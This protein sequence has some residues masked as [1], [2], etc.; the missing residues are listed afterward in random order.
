[1]PNEPVWTTQESVDVDVPVSSAWAFMTNVANWSDPPAE[2][3]L[4]GPF[5][6][7]AHGTTQMPGQPPTS[8]IVREVAHQRAYT[9]EVSVAAHASVRFQWRFDRVSEQRTTLTQRVELWGDDAAALVDTIRSAFEPSLA[10]GM[11]RVARMM[12]ER[13]AQDQ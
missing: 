7:G 4:E 3:S 12:A 13:A 8:W 6:A 2:F 1:M 10:S 5:V 9:I 11:Q